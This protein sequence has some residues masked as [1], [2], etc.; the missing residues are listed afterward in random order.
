MKGIDCIAVLK[1]LSEPTRLRI[2][3]R[4]LK[5]R[6]SVNDVVPELSVKLGTP[7]KQGQLIVNLRAEA[8]PEVLS[9]VVRDAFAL[10]VTKIPW[11]TATL[12]HMEHFRPGKPKPAYRDSQ[13]ASPKSTGWH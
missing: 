5:E 4:L 6:L 7:T 8:A 9:R 3:G 13:C 11:F 2:V 1:A 12:D 10:A